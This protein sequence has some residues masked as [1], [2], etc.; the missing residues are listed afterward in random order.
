M[1]KSPARWW[2]IPSAIFLFLAILFSAWRLQST[3][4]TDGLE[5]VRNLALLGL[6]VGLALGQSVFQKRSVTLLAIGYMLVL[7]TWQLLGMVEFGEEETYLGDRLIVLAGRL[8][9]GLSEFTAGRPV[10]DPLFFVAIFCIPYWFAA[11]FS[12]YQL[13]RYANALAAI[14]PSGIMMFVIYFNHYTSRDYSWMFGLYL[15]V[16]LLLLGRQKYLRDRQTWR[17]QHVQVSA[18]SGMDF[19][20]TIMVSAAILILIAWLAPSTLTFNA[21]ARTTWQNIS[22]KIFQKN[23]RLEN[24][25]AAAKKENLPVSDFY[26]NELSLGTKAKQSAAV[27]FLVYVPPSANE[28]PRL[29]WR[30]RVYDSF[31]NG[32]WVTTNVEGLNYEPQQ[33]DFDT[34]N[35]GERISMNFTFNVYIKG[36]TILYSAAQPSFVSHPANIVYKKIPE[37]ESLDIVAVQASPKLDA[38]ESYHANALIANPTIAELRTAGTEYPAWVSERYLQLPENFSTRI[39]ALAFDITADQDNP[40]D[41]TAAITNYLRTEIEYKPSISFPEQPDNPVDPLEYFLFDIKQGF[42]N[43]YATSEVLMLRSIGIPARLAVGFAQG[44]ANLQSTLFTVRER[45]AHAWPEV[46]FPA[47][48]WIEFEPT[49]NQD[50]LS[51]PEKREDLP[52]ADPI[53]QGTLEVDPITQEK[54]LI[55]QNIEKPAVSIT[56]NQIILIS[57]ATSLAL[58]A[59]IAFLLKRRFAPNTQ[60]AQILKNVV[61]RNGWETPLWLN[62]WVRWTSLTPIERSFQSINTGLRWMEKPQPVHIT[63]AERAKILMEL[64]PSAAPAIETL[65][66]EHQSA[67]FSRRGGNASLTRRA[68]RNVLYQ[69]LYLQIK[70]FILGYNYEAPQK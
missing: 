44:E 2:D 29:Y 46:Y 28:I 37:S 69:I 9:L 10:E 58:L 31:E 19:N 55:D 14:L 30:G 67:M 24:M 68:A 40:Y 59:V 61:E 38:G 56:R 35:M 25:F 34:P 6:F 5:H 26:R 51:R 60:T 64:V 53:P 45:D 20:N 32:R 1:E 17:E 23:D 70:S 33:G 7:L 3:G 47:Y 57:A 12:G 16:A 8:L 65:L 21:Q 4:W 18:E 66:R 22:N 27:A 49:G 63:P 48:G 62:R 11:L 15:F 50:E 36:Q 41:R 13:T 43:Y 54:P 42:C 39:Q 52:A